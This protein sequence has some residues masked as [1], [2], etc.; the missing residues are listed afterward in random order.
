MKYQYNAGY[1]IME[2]NDSKSRTGQ[3][4]SCVLCL[5]VLHPL[6]LCLASFSLESFV[7]QYIALREEPS[8]ARNPKKI[9]EWDNSG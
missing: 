5:L 4:N 6:V 2:K 3:V 7:S 8:T 1:R 9:A